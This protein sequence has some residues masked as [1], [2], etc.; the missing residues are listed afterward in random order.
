MKLSKTRT[1][2]HPLV[3]YCC[4]DLVITNR[5]GAKRRLNNIAMP[6]TQLCQEAGVIF[7][8]SVLPEPRE[9]WTEASRGVSC[10]VQVTWENACRPI[11]REQGTDRSRRSQYRWEDLMLK[12]L[13]E[14]VLPLGLARSHAAHARLLAHELWA[15]EWPTGLTAT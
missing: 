12:L 2:A 1:Y 5:K 13:N 4:N 11:T 8:Q 7:S 14:G 6:F 10:K 15:L 9:G 3:L